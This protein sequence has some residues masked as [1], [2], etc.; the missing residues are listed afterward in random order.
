MES[1]GDLDHHERVSRDFSHLAKQRAT[2]KRVTL[3]LMVSVPVIAIVVYYLIA[4][5]KGP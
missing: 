4:I 3:L 5:I 1:L 2:Q